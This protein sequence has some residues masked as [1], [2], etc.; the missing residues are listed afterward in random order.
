MVK[1]KVGDTVIGKFGYAK[2]KKIE[3][4]ENVGEKEGISIPAVWSKLV[5]QCVFDMDNGHF[6]YGYDLDY[7]N[8]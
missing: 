5:D 1:L 3:L 4:C 7:V 2:I 8:Y 6:E